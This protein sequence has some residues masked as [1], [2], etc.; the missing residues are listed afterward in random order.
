MSKKIESMTAKV[1]RL[2]ELYKLAKTGSR[3]EILLAIA[4]LGREATRELMAEDQRSKRKTSKATNSTQLKKQEL[5]TIAGSTLPSE[6]VTEQ[7]KE[8]GAH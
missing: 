6:T 2:R 8:K 7:L 5:R 4:E 1:V 3:A